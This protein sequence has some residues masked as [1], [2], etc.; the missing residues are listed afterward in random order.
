MN[1]LIFAC[2]YYYRGPDSYLIFVYYGRKTKLGI[3]ITWFTLHF[4]RKL[5]STLLSV[6]HRFFFAS[7]WHKWDVFGSWHPLHYTMVLTSDGSMCWVWKKSGIPETWNVYAQLHIFA[8]KR[9]LVERLWKV[10]WIWMFLLSYWYQKYV[11]M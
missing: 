10:R 11:K 6:R 4:P 9:S 3:L 7:A 1:K 2:E 5:L 8:L